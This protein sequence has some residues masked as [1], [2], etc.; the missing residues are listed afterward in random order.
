MRETLCSLN[1]ARHPWERADAV[2]VLDRLRCLLSRTSPSRALTEERRVGAIRR[3]AVLQG[4]ANQHTA[5]PHRRRG[6][7]SVLF[8]EDG[9]VLAAGSLGWWRPAGSACFWFS[10]NPSATNSLEQDGVCHAASR[11]CWRALQHRHAMM[12]HNRS[13]GAVTQLQAVAAPQLLHAGQLHR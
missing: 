8:S 5:C 12:M 9:L 6:T 1:I 11:R 2:R 10:L 4:A 3:T 13:L 7:L